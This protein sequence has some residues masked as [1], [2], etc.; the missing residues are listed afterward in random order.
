M[1]SFSLRYADEKG[2]DTMGLIQT[3]CLTDEDWMK[4]H[5]L[6]RVGENSTRTDIYAQTAREP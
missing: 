4:L 3:V 6:L 5:D 1:H 2:E